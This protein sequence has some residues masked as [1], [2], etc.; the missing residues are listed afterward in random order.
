MLVLAG[1]ACAGGPPPAAM[2]PPAPPAATPVP[3]H[4]SWAQALV[5][6]GDVVGAMHEVVPGGDTLRSEC[7]GRNSRATGEWASTLFG[8]IG[9]GVYG[10]VVTV[11]SY[12]GPGA[13]Q[14]P[15]VIVQVADAA[16]QAVWQTSGDDPATFT[17]GI[18]EESGSIDASLTNLLTNAAGVQVSGRWSCVT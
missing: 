12:R 16:G 3:A 13:Y 11:R 5:F 9:Q 15:D 2:A 8:P 14:A 1:A 10:L 7:S 6:T 17:V 18:G 4:G